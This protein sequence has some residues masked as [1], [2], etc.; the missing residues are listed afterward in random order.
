[1]RFVSSV[2][3]RKST[4]QSDPLLCCRA[5]ARETASSLRRTLEFA[6]VDVVVLD[7]VPRLDHLDV[8]ETADR[9]EEFELLLG[10]QSDRD[11][12]RVD[13]V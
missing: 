2:S 11:A 4:G 5:A 12:V 6:R 8:L 1:M 7:A 10:G 9:A 3:A 13:Q